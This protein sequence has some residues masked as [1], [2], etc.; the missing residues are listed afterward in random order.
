MM[1]HMVRRSIALLV[2]ALA[3]AGCAGEPID[4]AQFPPDAVLDCEDDTD[5]VI[6]VS[7][8]PDAAG[9]AT[10]SEALADMLAPFIEDDD[11]LQGPRLIGE[12]AASL[13][14]AQNREV[15]VALAIEGSPDNWFVTTVSGCS[16]FERF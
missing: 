12:G 13:L 14:D 4:L 11:Q 10:A 3:A 5:W 2:V 9:F 16:G 7:L 1:V 6:Q 15:V 8:D